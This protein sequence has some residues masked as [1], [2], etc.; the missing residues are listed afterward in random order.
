[1][2]QLSTEPSG[3]DALEAA[4]DDAGRRAEPLLARIWAE[5]LALERV[6]VDDDFFELGGDAELAERL[7]ARVGRAFQREIPAAALYARPTIRRLAPL[8]VGRPRPRAPEITGFHTNGTRRPFFFLHGDFEMSQGLYCMKLA[9]HLPDERPFYVLP[10]YLE[11]DDRLQTLEDVADYH[12]RAIRKLQPRGP[13]L[14]GGFCN[15]GLVAHEMARQLLSLGEEVDLLVVVDGSAN[16]VYIRPLRDAVLRLGRLLGISPARRRDA[17]LYL[18]AVIVICFRIY[19]RARRF[20]LGGHRRW[21]GDAA[22]AWAQPARPAARDAGERQRSIRYRRMVWAHVPGYYP[23]RVVLLLSEELRDWADLPWAWRKVAAEVEILPIAGTH[24]TCRTE[25][26][27]ELAESLK[28]CL[29]RSGGGV[30]RRTTSGGRR[31][32]PR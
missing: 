19:R 29:D 30:L 23:G 14:L 18:R 31:G 11:H 1:M 10:P 28:R 5:V 6:G 22:M 26:V 16:N 8:L 13:Y 20:L 21:D 27:G 3:W 32:S 9:R 7:M 24:E 4:P 15:G 17:F 2:D 25:F 12:L